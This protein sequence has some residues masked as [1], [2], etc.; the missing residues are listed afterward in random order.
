MNVSPILNDRDLFEVL[1]RQMVSRC[2]GA[3]GKF[4]TE[5]FWDFYKRI[6]DE[7]SRFVSE[8]D[9]VLPERWLGREDQFISGIWRGFFLSEVESLVY[10]E[11]EFP[12]LLKSAVGD[13]RKY[14][15]YTDK[16]DEVLRRRFNIN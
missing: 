1:T 3:T 11:P 13:K 14:F 12:R 10:G 2:L 16:I 5:I 4:S 6:F 8:H 9:F 15:F 7:F